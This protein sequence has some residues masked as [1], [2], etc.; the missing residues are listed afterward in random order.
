MLMRNINLTWPLNRFINANAKWESCNE[1]KCEMGKLQRR[2]M[3]NGKV[4]T[5][6]NAKWESCSRDKFR[7]GIVA[8]EINLEKE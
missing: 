4:A 7:K 6:A 1:G 3:R 2:Q 5:K 8:L